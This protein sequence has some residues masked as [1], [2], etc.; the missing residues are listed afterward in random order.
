MRRIH[1]FLAA[2]ALVAQV[3]TAAATPFI[4]EFHYDNVGIDAGEFIEIAGGAGW[5]LSGW[6]LVL[7]NGNPTVRTPYTTTALSGTFTNQSNG[8]GFLRFDYP[9]N[10]IQNGSGTAGSNAE[11][12]GFALVD[13][14]NNVVQFL[15]YE[16]SFTGA[17]GVAAGRTSADVG[18]REEGTT[19]LGFSLR[20][21][22]T[23]LAGTAGGSLGSQPNGFTW[24]APA[25]ESGAALNAGQV[26]TVAPPAPP[27][28]PP[29][30]NDRTIAQIQGEAHTSPLSGQAVSTTGFVSQ[31]VSNG[32]YLMSDRPDANIGTSEGLFVFTGSAGAKPA[33][34]DLVRVNGNVSE[35]LP[36]GSALNT[37]ITQLTGSTFTVNSS[38]NALA[39][40]VIGAGG[41]TPP[42][43]TI[44]TSTSIANY[45]P[46]NAGRDFYESLEG[47][48]V[49]VQ[50]ATAVAPTVVFSNGNREV[51]VRS[52]A[53][54][55]SLNARGGLTIAGDAS[56]ANVQGADFNP[57][58]LQIDAAGVNTGPLV[59]TGDV[60]GNVTGVVSY[61][62][63]AYEIVPGVVPTAT[64]GG[65]QREVST[66]KAGNRRMTVASYNVENLLPGQASRFTDLAG[67]IINELNTPDVIALQEIVTVEGGVAQDPAV[68]LQNLVNAIAAAGGPSYQFA[69]RPSE[70]VLDDRIV[71]AYLY[72]PSRVTLAGPVEYVPGVSAAG[73][74]YDDARGPLIAQ[75][76]FN[77]ETVTVVNNHWSSRGGSQPL[78][79]ANQPPLNGSEARRQGQGEVLNAYLD[80]LLGGDSDASVVVLGDLN[81]FY[82]ENP[83]VALRGTGADQILY[84]LY[85]LLALNERY[86]YNFDG[87]AQSLD[88]I[89]ASGALFGYA[90]LFDIVH[91]NSEF[92]NAFSDHDPLVAS[93]LVS[94]PSA[95]LLIFLGVAGLVGAR[96]RRARG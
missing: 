41:R 2:T 84:G 68:T 56:P 20:L 19:P 85:E 37:T 69:F 10:G 4:N 36:G 74:P 66:L 60:L 31:V 52:D 32:Y 77:G 96:R 17:T 6:S 88:Y 57:E 72:N 40:V 30:A 33:V 55:N 27:P 13:P 49:T 79:G 51:W 81:S 46:V 53:P 54:T 21:T 39:A 18:V 47:M 89:Y 58:R 23:Q 45:D 48:L 42:L 65:L 16:G 12:D 75:F 26:F 95:G 73:S 38:G 76:V 93:F 91:R 25:A 24:A 82:W 94:E 87:N 50:N 59:S 14:S 83:Q 64:S 8:W 70:G 80:T 35:F 28:P 3:S 7:Y 15:S 78:Y 5:D 34:G 9:S 1:A 43:S 29:P 61:D 63:G 44:E 62:F 71:N 67:Q 22:G 90:P 92:S 86:S 11:P